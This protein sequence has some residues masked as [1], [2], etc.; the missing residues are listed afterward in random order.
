MSESENQIVEMNK[1]V[2]A[3][4]IDLERSIESASMFLSMQDKIRKM[5]IKLTNQN[6]WIAE[7]GKPYLQWTGAS[8]IAAAFGVSYDDLRFEKE[9]IKDEIGEYINF[10][11]LATVRWNGRAVP[12]IGTGSTRDSFFGKR[13]KQWIP[14]SEIDLNNIKKKAV[15]NMLNRGIKSLL[16]L[17]FTWEEIESYS[18]G[19]IKKSGVSGVTFEKGKKGGKIP[20]EFDVIDKRSQIRSMLLEIHMNDK[21]KAS[22]FLFDL[23][24]NPAK[25][26][27]GKRT[28]DDLTTGQIIWIHRTIKKQWDDARKSAIDSLPKANPEISDD[29]FAT[30]NKE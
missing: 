17:S 23:T 7:G 18:D 13:N 2:P 15:T 1:N 5:S 25:G 16:G 26:Y 3:N 12:E 8:K 22:D 21:K 24:D 10:H 9:T 6:D 20:E 29:E 28:V 11:A 30:E 4:K 14:I 27:A 19:A